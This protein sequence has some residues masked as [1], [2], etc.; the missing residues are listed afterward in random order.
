[1][2]PYL[3]ELG[4]M[5]MIGRLVKML[6]RAFAIADIHSPDG[7]SMPEINSAH[8]DL[9][10]TLGDISTETIDYILFMAK[11]VKVFG[12]LGNHDPK[13]IPGLDDRHG[14]IAEFRG[15]KFGFLNGA[16]KYKDEPNHFTE[17][18]MRKVIEKM[19]RVDVVLSHAPP[20][21]ANLN[22]DKLHKGFE[23]FDEFIENYK[24]KC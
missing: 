24:P 21:C 23:A 11:Q 20:F 1:M 22:E 13:E 12:V 4:S 19:P 6:I 16:P 2:A 14:K 7:F 10:L 5:F 3:L 8:F 9:V 17:K 15:V 18:Q